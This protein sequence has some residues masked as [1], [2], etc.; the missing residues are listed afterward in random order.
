MSFFFFPAARVVKDLFT[1]KCAR[2]LSIHFPRCIAWD[3]F[4]D[5]DGQLGLSFHD[6]FVVLGGNIV[7]DLRTVRSLAEQECFQQELPEAAGQH[8]LF[9]CCPK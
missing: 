1:T 6:G 5:S 9:S 3:R 4:G 8:V 2:E 7:S